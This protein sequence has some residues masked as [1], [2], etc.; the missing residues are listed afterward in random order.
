MDHNVDLL[1][2]NQHIP[3]QK[4]IENTTDLKLYP[5]ITRPSR[6]THHSVTL[7]DNIYMNDQLHRSFDSMLLISD[8]SDHLPVVTL[9]K[10]TKL[11]NKKP[12]VFESRCLNEAKLKTVNH[13]LMRK[14]WIGILMGATCNEKIL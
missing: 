4:L 2:G 5:T 6:I 13:Q 7:I 11:L 3:T 10:Q 8:I 14:D 12:L 1:K 9:L